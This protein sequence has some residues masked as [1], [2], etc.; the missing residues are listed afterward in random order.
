MRYVNR[1]VLKSALGI[2]ATSTSA[3]DRLDDAAEAVSRL[4]DQHV[5]YAFGPSSGTRDYTA[6]EATC[7][8]LDRPLLAVDA[9][10]TASDG[11][12]FGTTMTTADYWLAPYN[13]TVESP[14]RPFWGIET[15]ASA[16]A[17][18][19]TTRRSVRIVGTWGYFDERIT[20][21]ATLA[22]DITSN[23]TTIQLNGATALHPGQTILMGAER[24]LVTQTPASASGV[25]TSNINVRRAMDGTTNSTHS[26]ATSIQV[27]EYPVVDRLALY[28]AQM[29]YRALDAPL[30]MTGGMPD[31]GSRVN[32]AGGLHPFVQRR[33]NDSFRTPRTG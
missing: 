28:Q 4:F 27:Y 15:R 17:V 9:L 25:H 30:G 6:K 16:T 23:T 8:Y 24:M 10:R 13:A 19:P 1:T 3:N 33:L 22:T 7:L 31:G 11:T 14:R 5:G 32:A 18:F 29:D 21:T 2:N 12:T 26:S 20:S